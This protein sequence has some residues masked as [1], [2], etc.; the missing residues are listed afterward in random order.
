MHKL[1]VEI[2]LALTALLTSVMAQAAAPPPYDI[3][4]PVYPVAYTDAQKDAQRVAGRAVFHKINT[5]I[6][7]GAKTFAV[8]P[9]VYRIPKDGPDSKLQLDGV[10]N[11]TLHLGNTEFVLENGGNLV[12]GRNCENL[13]IVGPC[14]ID[15]ATPSI[16]QGRLLTYDPQTGAATVEIMPGYEVADSDKG[17]VDAFSPQGIYLANPS[18]AGFTELKVTDGAKRLISVKLSAKDAIFTEIYQPGALLALRIHGGP[19]LIAARDFHGFTLKDID[20]YT[21]AGIGWGGG[22]GDWKFINIKGVRRP[23]TNRLMGAGGCQMG[24]HGGSVLFDGC[25]FSNTADDLMDYYGGGL[26]MCVRQDGPRNL[27][28]WAGGYAVGDTLNFYAHDGFHR[29]VSARV[30]AVTELKDAALQ[31]EAR[32][33]VKNT[34]KARDI[35]DQTLRRVTLD[36]DVAV[37]PGDYVENGTG[38]RADTFTI[39]HCYFHDSGVRVMVQGFRHGLFENNTFERVSGGLALTYDAW[40]WEG[41]TVQDVT[42]RNNVFRNTTFRNAW[43][44]GRA[45]IT[46]GS[47]RAPTGPATDGVTRGV[48][49]TGN[50]IYNSSTGGIYVG[51]AADVIIQGNVI[52]HAKA[53]KGEAAITLNS[54]FGGTVTGNKVIGCGGPALTVTNS[55]G[56]KAPKAP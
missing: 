29:L 47:D 54:V 36:R 49:I 43:G 23:G 38:N 17:T 7:A 18:W 32:D 30:V 52:D 41:P 27:V 20:V 15:A 22:D 12:D 33:L 34:L 56:V 6:A 4:A 13:A 25:E 19:N 3:H 1:T 53:P 8:P 51:N 26:L 14:K 2:A 40:W 45:A 39:R 48:R 44:T 21:G 50:K 5:A 28:T 46:V 37:S 9:G 11:F 10:K 31:T 42:V 55:V 16:T 35:G 24:S